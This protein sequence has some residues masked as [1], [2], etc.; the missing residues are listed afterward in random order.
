MFFPR[1]PSFNAV[2]EDVTYYKNVCLPTML[3]LLPA[4]F[5]SNIA[6]NEQVSSYW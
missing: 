6:E 4:V 3:S 2:P 5:G 1:A